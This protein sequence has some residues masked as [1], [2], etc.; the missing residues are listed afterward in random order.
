ME[1]HTSP[2]TI[3]WYNHSKTPK[4]VTLSL[5]GYVAAVGKQ[6][7][8]IQR[9]VV[10]STNSPVAIGQE[11]QLVIVIKKLAATSHFDDRKAILAEKTCR[12][13]NRFA[14]ER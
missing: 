4:L 8:F 2:S 11:D 3:Q 10:R 13:T 12:L 1:K 5:A 6:H 7:T 14:N 9:N